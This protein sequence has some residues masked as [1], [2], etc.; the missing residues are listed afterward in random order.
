MLKAD[1]PSPRQVNH[2]DNEYVITQ[3]L[4][5]PGIRQV[6]GKS[7]EEGRLVLIMEH[8]HGESV[9]TYM[10]SHIGDIGKFLEIGIEICRI[11]NELHKKGIIHRDINGN[12]IIYD[13][14]EQKLRLID[15]EL[16]I[17]LNNSTRNSQINATNPIEGTLA[18]ISPE[19]TGRINRKVDHR[20]D[21]YSLGATFYEMLTGELPFDYQDVVEMVHAHVAVTPIAPHKLKPEAEIP[22]TISRIVMKLMAK[23]VEERYQSAGNLLKDLEICQQQWMQSRAIHLIELEQQIGRFQL[24][25]KL[26]GREESLNQLQETYQDVREGKLAMTLIPSYTGLGKTALVQ[27]LQTPIN[28]TGGYLIEGR[29]EQF[30]HIIP[31]SAWIQAFGDFTN[32]L[33]TQDNSQLES[34]KNKILKAVEHNGAALTNVIPRL[35]LIIGNQKEPIGDLGPE[36]AQNR[37]LY[38]LTSFVRTIS[39]AR[40]PIVIFL[41]DIQWID[42]P[43]MELLHLLSHDLQNKHLWIIAAWRKEEENDLVKKLYQLKD[44]LPSRTEIIELQNLSLDQINEWIS[45]TLS[46]STDHCQQLGAILLDKTQGNPFFL[47]QTLESIYQKDLLYYRDGSW[48]WDLGGIQQLNITDNVVAF[49]TEKVQKLPAGSREMMKYAACIGNDFQLSVLCAISEQAPVYAR[50]HLEPAI[51]EGLIIDMKGHYKFVHDQIREAVYSL[52]P[53]EDTQKLHLKTGRYL[54]EIIPP[55]RWEMNIFEI[56]NQWNRGKAELQGKEDQIQLARLNLIAGKKSN[57]AAAYKTAL[58]YL[59]QGMEPLYAYGWQN[60]YQ[61]NLELYREAAKAAYLSGDY[62]RMEE[63]IDKLLKQTVQVI[64]KAE[65]YELNIQALI[66]QNKLNQAAETGLYVLEQLNIRFPEKTTEFKVRRYFKKVYRK[67]RKKSH[68]DL[69]NLPQMEDSYMLAVMRIIYVV[70][71]VLHITRPWLTPLLTLRQIELVLKEGN[72]VFSSGIFI[73]YAILLTAQQKIE[74]GYNFGKLGMQLLERTGSREMIARSYFI[75]YSTLAHFKEH[76]HEAIVPLMEGYKSGLSSGDLA[77]ASFCINQY[78]Y[79]RFITGKELKQLEKDTD[80]YIEEISQLKQ[81]TALNYLHMAKAVVQSLTTPGPDS[82]TLWGSVGQEAKMQSHFQNSQD[83]SGLISFYFNK[84]YLAYLFEEYALAFQYAEKIELET[85]DVSS[86]FPIPSYYLFDSLIRLHYIPNASKKEASQLL[87][88]VKE[89]QEKLQERAEFAPM[90]YLHKWH[91]VEAE[92][93]RVLGQDQEARECYEKAID[94]ARDYEYLNEEALAWELAGK[95]YRT[96]RKRFLAETYFQQ[97]AQAYQRWGAMAKVA[98]L[99]ERYPRF[100]RSSVPSSITTTTTTSSG[101]STSRDALYGM[102]L[103]SITRASRALSGEVV[104]SNLLE[105]LMQIVIENAGAT[106]GVFIEARQD[107]LWVMAVAESEQSVQIQEPTLLGQYKYVSHSIV[108]Y[109]ARTQQELALDQP[110]RDPQYAKDGYLQQGK[111]EAVLAFPVVHK[112]ELIAVIYLENDLTEGAFT[113]ERVEVLR[114]LSAQMA[115]SLDNAR[116]YEQLDEKVKARTRELNKKNQELANTLIQL[117][118]TQSKLLESEKMASL[119]QLTAGIAHEINNPINFITGNIIPLSRDIEDLKEL[120]SKVD[121]LEDNLNLKE[122]LEEVIEFKEEIDAEYLFEEIELLLKGIHEGAIRTRDI[123]AGLR[124]F[125]R[126]DEDDFK[127]ADIHEGLDATLMLLNSKLKR[128]IEVKKNYA[129]LPKISCLPGKLNQVFMNILNNSIQA[130]LEKDINDGVITLSTSLENNTVEIRIQDN[131]IG[132]EE[133]VRKRIFEPFYTT[134]DVGQGTGLG[135]S[136]TYGI[137]ERHNGTIEVESEK[138]V[139]TVFIIRFPGDLEI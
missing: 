51:A 107:G 18:Y 122:A 138:G 27:T 29:F 124:N 61:I 50:E 28:E 90:N 105:K 136:I 58:V 49:M 32:Q 111:P 87:K 93:Q 118:S 94:L 66:A 44:E 8:I 73:S 110:A 76:S 39:T 128:G 74:E 24:S 14:R 15:F 137:I 86:V 52:I 139:G 38:I 126:L 37:F 85:K 4:N 72:S 67:L 3:D 68:Y 101:S 114:V 92:R 17:H 116:L 40:H 63:L 42:G 103:E 10:K 19:Q 96:C 120:L 99:N 112:G 46:C 134:K 106:R 30:Q 62:T 20:T 123:V 41:D 102:D 117:Q 48:Q 131:G 97:A 21:L 5:I 55:D 56:V 100:V 71:P 36:E 82:H 127:Y 7:R 43:S 88:R 59:E 22:E 135:L 26:Y 13:S 1:M 98:Q 6:Y 16:A 57:T 80:H 109:A 81:E 108:N 91:I 84:L 47:R 129:N 12:N 77:S 60:N 121:E 23:N 115:I 25:N 11:L 9:R 53:S 45:D 113:S 31:Y 78:L 64:D 75:F 79:A 34:W 104:L 54:L 89:N 119:G 83:I 35:N 70:A 2:F 130:I 69:L 125:S 65:P 133:E 132:M 33:L 95:F